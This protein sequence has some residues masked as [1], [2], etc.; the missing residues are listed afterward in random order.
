MKT[1]EKKIYPI[2]KQQMKLSYYK[3]LEGN[4]LVKFAASR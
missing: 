3:E 4:G 1:N 2:R